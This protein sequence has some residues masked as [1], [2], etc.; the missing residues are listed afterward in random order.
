[1]PSV[2]IIMEVTHVNVKMV[3][4]VLVEVQMVATIWMSVRLFIIHVL[5]MLHVSMIM[6]YMNVNAFLDTLVMDSN[7]MILTSVSLGFIIVPS[8]VIVSI[9]KAV[10]YVNAMLDIRKQLMLLASAKKD[11]VLVAVLIWMNAQPELI[12]VLIFIFAIIL[13]AVI[14]VTVR[15]D[16]LVMVINATMLMSVEVILKGTLLTAI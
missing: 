13:L 2:L 15:M 3:L 11:R 6:V 10:T 7:A 1:M 4:V 16:I 5:Y 12:L 14:R 8:I 9:T